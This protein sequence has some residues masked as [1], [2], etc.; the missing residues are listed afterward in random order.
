M[1]AS[2]N[3]HPGMLWYLAI[4]SAT[5]SI[6]FGIINSLLVLY[7]SGPMHMT[8]HSKYA[9]FSAYNAMIFTLPLIGGMSAG[10]FG[11][12]KAFVLGCLLCVTGAFVIAIPNSFS[13]HLGLSLFATGVGFYVPTYL[14][15]IGKIYSRHDHRRESGYTLAYVIS[16]IG[17]LISAVLGGYLERYFGFTTAFT[18]GG[19]IMAFQLLTYPFV[20]PKLRNHDGSKIEANQQSGEI[21]KTIF[22]ILA[23]AIAIP[24]CFVLLQHANFT[25]KLLLVLVGIEVVV[26]IFVA[27][28]QK[29]R[30]DR[31]RLFAFI[32]LSIISIGFWALYILEPSLLTIFIKDNV[33]RM[34]GNI[35]IPPSTF[36]G[37]DPFYIVLLGGIFSAMWIRL[38]H[39]NKD[40]SLPSKYTLALF[41]MALG[42]G[43]FMASTYLSGGDHKVALWWVV[44]GY[45]FLTIG[46]LLI[47]PIG[48]SMVGKLAPH[49]MEGILM[50]VWQTF[51][52]VSAAIASYMTYWAKVPGEATLNESNHIYFHAFGKIALSAGALGVV[53]L[54]MIPFVKKLIKP[55]D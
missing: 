20:L 18:V 19:I 7:L 25:N 36:Y 49:G 32:I 31:F 45:L 33:D 26:L 46:E 13:L 1:T 9:L 6:P 16:N 43:I 48:Q 15:L 17:F 44:F 34:I 52:G 53:S 22:A 42:M 39:I 40:P 11:Y 38:K 27:I 2:V 47:G 30:I 50:G 14:V 41:S 5:M 3:K 21:S 12:R 55:K 51:T 4:V 10:R 37:L 35:S 8:G 24:V 28:L 23:A 29:R 54:I